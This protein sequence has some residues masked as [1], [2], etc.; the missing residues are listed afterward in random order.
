MIKTVYKINNPEELA[1]AFRKHQADFEPVLNQIRF[2]NIDT[3]LRK[4]RLIS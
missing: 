3:T 1:A 4:D 2:E